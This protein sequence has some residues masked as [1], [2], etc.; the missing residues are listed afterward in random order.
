MKCKR[1]DEEYILRE[2]SEETDYCDNCAQD[3]VLELKELLEQCEWSAPIKPSN[4]S[5]RCPICSARCDSTAGHEVNCEMEAALNKNTMQKA[6]SV[7]AAKARR[8]AK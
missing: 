8:F 3:L 7:I 5:G 6:W 4:Q 2:C 1:C